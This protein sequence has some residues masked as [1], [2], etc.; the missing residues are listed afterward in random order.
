MRTFV[1]NIQVAPSLYQPL[2]LEKLT[3]VKEEE[4]IGSLTDSLK[5]MGITFT[6]KK[7]QG[8]KIFVNDAGGEIAAVVS[9]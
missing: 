7:D 3:F 6:I 8:R 4:A 9:A 2:G 1:Y 5:K